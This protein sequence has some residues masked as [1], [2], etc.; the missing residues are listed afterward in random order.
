[1]GIWNIVRHDEQVR[2]CRFALWLDFVKERQTGFQVDCVETG[3]DTVPRLLAIKHAAFPQHG[4]NDGAIADTASGLRSLHYRKNLT[5]MYTTV[6]DRFNA[7]AQ[8]LSHPKASASSC[9]YAA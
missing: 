5:D 4:F 9:R 3:E 2:F 6:M 8:L 7:G 1:M